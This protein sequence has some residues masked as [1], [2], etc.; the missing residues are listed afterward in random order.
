M[1]ARHARRRY[2]AAVSMLL[3]L[4]V[5]VEA[6]ILY[7][8][9]PVQPYAAGPVHTSREYWIGKNISEAEKEFGTPTF[10]EELIETGGM[11]VMYASKKNPVHFVFETDPGGRIIKAARVE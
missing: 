11:L 8:A 3:M 1:H 2:L 6:R 4:A 5:L 7:A 9:G 10:S